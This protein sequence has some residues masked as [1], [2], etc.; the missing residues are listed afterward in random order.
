[1]SIVN[2]KLSEKR[3][4]TTVSSAALI[5]AVQNN[6]GY[7]ATKQNFLKEIQQLVTN[8]TI[9]ISGL[10]SGFIGVI[11]KSD[12][13]DKDGVYIAS[14]SGTYT[15]AGNLVV[16]LNANITF[17]VVEGSQT[18][19][20][21]VEIP[22]SQLGYEVVGGLAK[23]DSLITAGQGGQWLIT[24]DFTLD[25]NKTLPSGVSLIFNGGV[26]TG[27]SFTITGNNS[28]ISADVKQIF[29]TGTKLNGTWTNKEYFLE[30]W[31]VGT[32]GTVG[33]SSS[34]EAASV[35]GE[36]LI[37]PKMVNL[38]TVVTID[39]DVWLCGDLNKT[40]IVSNLS[41]DL[42]KSNA[43]RI[44]LTNFKYVS[45]TTNNTLLEPLGDCDYI[46]VSNNIFSP[47]EDNLSNYLVTIATRSGGAPAVVAK[48]IVIFKNEVTNSK[49]FYADTIV[50]DRID[51]IEN[52][53]DKP[54]QFTFRVNSLLVDLSASQ[55][56][57]I[58]ARRNTITDINGG[59]LDKSNTARCF[60]IK[61]LYAEIDDNTLNGAESTTASNFAYIKKGT[62]RIFDN[63]I[64]AIKGQS[65]TA[66][67]DD[68]QTTD[69]NEDDY[70]LIYDNVFDQ[71]GISHAETP[72]TCIRINEASN[73]TVCD[74][75]Y[76]FLK[77]Y[78]CRFYHADLNT[79]NYPNNCVFR[80][81]DIYSIDFPVVVGVMNNIINT[82]IKDNTIHS[83]SNTQG[84]NIN[85]RAECRAV[86]IY[87]S[88]DV[89]AGIVNV[90]VSGNDIIYAIGTVFCA[91]IY[92][93]NAVSSATIKGIKI[94]SNTIEE[95]STNDGDLVRFTGVTNIS[96]D[97]DI[98]NNIGF[99]GMGETIGQEPT[100]IRKQNNLLT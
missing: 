84:T 69:P 47:K 42:F 7:S 78:A 75:K 3:Q 100:T 6:L 34:I 45:T 37:F 4:I 80:D 82:T 44:K 17:I 30:W 43:N 55:V 10:M 40:T 98:A 64:K 54:N 83:I 86:D 52:K 87:Q 35:L 5:Y 63:T 66:I 39:D 90:R 76:F 58:N 31:G 24:S 96:E 12:I 73:V 88:N 15:N 36:K 56:D 27:N 46:E 33:A 9:S 62:Y 68:K 29:G 8:N 41:G 57:V 25:G 53:V 95:S 67:I 81:N 23:F 91:T 85:A 26:I 2:Q 92:R 11:G 99:S 59:I 51:F 94:I 49:V 97:V 71:E 16:D 50:S 13:P 28:L 18:I 19:F 77:S 20:N 89:G 70:I 93:G 32:D 65:T 60:Q 61:A 1:M 74:N 48:E 22:V 38:D 14:E 21:K 79:L 72:E